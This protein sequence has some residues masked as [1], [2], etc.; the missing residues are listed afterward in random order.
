MNDQQKAY[1]ILIVVEAT[2][3]YQAPGS[4]SL[5]SPEFK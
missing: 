1:K 5:H 2:P 3:R 4:D